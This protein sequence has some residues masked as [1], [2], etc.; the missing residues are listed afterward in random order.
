MTWLLLHGTP[1]DPAVWSGVVD[2]LGRGSV[3]TPEATPRPGDRTPQRDI[4][5]R[6]VDRLGDGPADIDLVGHSFG[7]QVALEV[8]LLAPARVRTLTM[9][10]ARSTPFPPFAATATAVRG[11]APVDV[12]AG[13]ARWFTPGELAGD[14]PAVRYARARLEHADRNAWAAALD[15]IATYDASARVAAVTA[16]TTS[17]AAELD[18][19]SPPDA[20]GDIVAFIPTA[21][22]EVLAGAMHMSPFVDP[23]GLAERLR[24]AAAWTG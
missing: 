4:A 10:C 2:H 20:M 9:V 24:A 15:A 23:A 1:L 11:G 8:A 19:V 5:L 21:R 16:P 14:G 18:P 3:L 12:A 17:L 7:G 22:L 13:L 6:L